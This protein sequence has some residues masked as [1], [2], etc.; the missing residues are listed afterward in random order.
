MKNELIKKENNDKIY[1]D[2]KILINQSKEKIYRTVNTEMLYL[3]WNIGKIIVDIQDGKKRAKYGESVLEQLSFKLTNEFGNGFS[4]RN[5]R[6]IRQFYLFFPNWTSVMANLTW[7]H[8]IEIIK[9]KEEVKR[10]FY[11][12][13]CME[14]KWSVREL[15]RQIKSRMFERILISNDNEYSEKNS[16]ELSKENYFIF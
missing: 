8:Y 2:I 13:E 15:Q 5:L 6:R 14:A 7:T 4:Y 11:M 10:N 16:L 1:S 12:K 3:Y 9:I